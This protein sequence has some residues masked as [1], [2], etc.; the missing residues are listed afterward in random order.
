MHA[1]TEKLGLD[2]GARDKTSFC[3]CYTLRS[4]FNYQMHEREKAEDALKQ[5]VSHLL[6]LTRLGI[7]LSTSAEGG[8]G[9]HVTLSFQE[10]N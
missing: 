4:S 6:L 1:I 5:Y 7:M 9:I 8:G 3:T 2:Q 10:Y